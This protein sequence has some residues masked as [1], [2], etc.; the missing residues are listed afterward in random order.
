MCMGEPLGRPSSG[1]HDQVGGLSAVDRFRPAKN[2]SL[3]EAAESS[4]GRLFED[5]LRAV[6]E[7]HLRLPDVA[8]PTPSGELR[9]YQLPEATPQE[10]GRLD[11]TWVQGAQAKYRRSHPESLR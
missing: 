1:R 6:L 3:R 9:S 2:K 11:A 7:Q 4:A 8:F 5:E 10:V